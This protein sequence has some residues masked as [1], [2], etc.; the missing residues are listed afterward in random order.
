MFSYSYSYSNNNT[1]KYEHVFLENI[2]NITNYTNQFIT[3]TDKKI[4][5]SNDNTK[6]ALSSDIYD[7][8]YESY[9]YLLKK[10]NNNQQI[11]DDIFKSVKGL[12]NLSEFNYKIF[13]LLDYINVG[14]NNNTINKE[15]D[16]YPDEL[17]THELTDDSD[18]ESVEHSISRKS[19]PDNE[20]DN[21]SDKQQ[22]ELKIVASDDNIITK[23]DIEQLDIDDG[24]SDNNEEVSE[25]EYENVYNRTINNIIE[26]DTAINDNNESTIT[27][28]IKSNQLSSELTPNNELTRNDIIGDYDDTDYYNTDEKMKD[29]LAVSYKRRVSA[30]IQKFL[31][32]TASS[33]KDDCTYCIK[34]NIK[35]HNKHANANTN[36]N[37]N[38]NVNANSKYNTTKDSHSH[39][40]NIGAIDDIDD[41]KDKLTFNIVKN[42]IKNKLKSW[43]TSLKQCIKDIPI[44]FSDC[45]SGM[46]C[47]CCSHDITVE[48]DAQPPVR[49]EM[50]DIEN[51]IR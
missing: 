27:R 21:E 26:D 39:S 43:Y 38:A 4:V 3:I 28:R 19:E 25:D 33:T 44:G 37:T 13:D 29:I 40:I 48:E 6:I 51:Q 32:S 35:N 49:Q 41:K 22:S 12:R 45:F 17:N 23:E 9:D 24:F 46:T 47:V 14:I 1:N 11:L 15:Y 8:L 42:N 10:Y 34:Y 31:V 18:Y 2:M 20:S 30:K 36:A 7:L 5:Y 16:F 50:S